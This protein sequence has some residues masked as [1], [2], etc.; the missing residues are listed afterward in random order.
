MG[1]EGFKPASQEKEPTIGT[2][3]NVEGPNQLD[4]IL[5]VIRQK[6]ELAKVQLEKA[7]SQE[8]IIGE[9]GF[10]VEPKEAA[11]AKAKLDYLE[12]AHELF[13]KPVLESPKSQLSLEVVLEGI[14]NY[15]KHLNDEYARQFGKLDPND[16][17][18]TKQNR[19]KKMWGEIK[20]RDKIVSEFSSIT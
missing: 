9:S 10:A 1:M 15:T 17:E 7:N 6:I 11:Q 18:E 3:E 19:A 14:E 20:L 12:K 13:F 16:V 8:W 5:N 2:P 4:N